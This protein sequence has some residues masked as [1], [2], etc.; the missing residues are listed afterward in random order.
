MGDITT[1]LE[2][3]GGGIAAGIGAVIVKLVL[4]GSIRSNGILVLRGTALPF[5]GIIAAL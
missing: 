2:D 4:Q 3:C 1:S 5:K